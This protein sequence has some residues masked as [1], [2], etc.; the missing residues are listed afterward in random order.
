MLSLDLESSVRERGRGECGV[1]LHVAIE[2][3]W[4]LL[5]NISKSRYAKRGSGGGVRGS[6]A[7]KGQVERGSMTLVVLTAAVTEFVNYD[8]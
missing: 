6:W 2:Q 8:L 5:V 1:L 4:Y 3:N 7:V